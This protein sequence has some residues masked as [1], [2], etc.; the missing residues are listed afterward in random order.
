MATAAPATNRT[1][2]I[3]RGAIV[4]AVA[5]W[6]LLPL[7][8]LV[9]GGSF[10]WWEAWSWCALLLV[11]MTLFLIW[12]ARNDPELLARRFKAREEDAI[13][14]RVV[15]VGLP[16]YLAALVL[17]G[18]DHRHGWSE[19]PT[20]LVVAALALSLASYL[21]ILRVLFE[22][23]WAG[24]TIETWQGQKL[25]SSGPYAVVRHPMYAGAL[26]LWLATPVAL[27]SWWALLPALAMVPVI[28]VR[29]RNEEALLVRE[30]DGYEE[31][32]HEVRYRLIPRVF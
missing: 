18:L 13:Q 21:L 26:V 4:R 5:A 19:I 22:N 6:A 27:G 15:T 9:T 1:K 11:P 29:L 3:V 20:A 2:G 31:Y 28:V 23:R 24:R 10:G 16:F 17:P 7:F 25:I 30:L 8:F 14:R 32:R 12:A